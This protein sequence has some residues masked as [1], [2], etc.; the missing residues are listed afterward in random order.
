MNIELKWY[1]NSDLYAVA[2]DNSQ[3]LPARHA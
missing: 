3:L 2:L 1:F